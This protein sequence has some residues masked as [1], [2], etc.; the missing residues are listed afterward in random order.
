MPACERGGAS[1]TSMNA[2]PL[3]LALDHGIRGPTKNKSYF[4]RI[5]EKNNQGAAELLPHPYQGLR[6]S[7]ADI[8]RRHQAFAQRAMDYCNIDERRRV[9]WE[10]IRNI[11]RTLQEQGSDAWFDLAPSEKL[12]IET[13]KKINSLVGCFDELDAI[14][15]ARAAA[16]LSVLAQQNKSTDRRFIASYK[17]TDKMVTGYIELAKKQYNEAVSKFA[18]LIVFA[19]P[20]RPRVPPPVKPRPAPAASPASSAVDATYTLRTAVAKIANDACDTE[21]QGACR[22]V[23][24][25][26]SDGADAADLVPLLAKVCAKV[27]SR[28]RLVQSI[29]DDDEFIVFKVLNATPPGRALTL[30]EFLRRTTGSM[31]DL[32]DAIDTYLGEDHT[33]FDTAFV[34]LQKEYLA[35]EKW[36]N[37]NV[38]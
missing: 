11:F 5:A 37:F 2:P 29:Q 16:P 19:W 32:V 17:I 33:A 34:A 28:A 6:K 12:N 22:S 26:L 31:T 18:P 7:I 1:D 3:E 15:A 10:R 9:V 4:E 24:P 13:K 25:D 8:I 38:D 27:S 30:D 21:L 20:T 36:G 14:V 23:I 35:A